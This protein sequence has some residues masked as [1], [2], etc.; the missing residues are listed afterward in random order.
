MGKAPVSLNTIITR[1][2][3]NVIKERNRY[4]V[5][6]K[7]H[8][9]EYFEIF[10]YNAGTVCYD[11]LEMVEDFLKGVLNNNTPRGLITH[12][13]INCNGNNV[14]IGITYFSKSKEDESDT[15]TG[16][17]IECKTES[18]LKDIAAEF[19]DKVS[20]LDNRSYRV[21]VQGSYTKNIAK[22]NVY[23]EGSAKFNSLLD[24][25]SPI[26]V[27]D[28]ESV[29]N[30]ILEKLFI[31]GKVLPKDKP[32]TVFICDGFVY[33]YLKISSCDIIKIDNAK[34]YGLFYAVN[35]LDYESK[36]SILEDFMNLF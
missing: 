18:E 24:K 2:L 16:P 4:F 11:T 26:D 17:S 35:S 1:V 21:I 3:I 34:D 32:K 12:V 19:M 27:N 28:I 7:V 10:R 6:K 8:N 33:K 25:I 23:K 9:S 29:K 15:G 13:D 14:N 22:I 31:A 36:E 20:S 30:E 5:E